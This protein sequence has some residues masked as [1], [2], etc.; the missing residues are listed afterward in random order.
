MADDG[1][2]I[3]VSWSAAG[4]WASERSWTI[5]DG[6]LGGTQI[7]SGDGTNPVNDLVGNCSPPPTNLIPTSGNSIH[8]DCSGSVYDNGGSG[9]DYSSSAN[10]SLTIYPDTPGALVNITGTSTTE[11]NFDYFYVYDGETVTPGAL[12][13]TYTGS[14][15]AVNHTSSDASGALTIRLTSDGTVTESGVDLAVTCI[16]PCEVPSSLTSS[17]ETATTATISWTVPSSAPSDGYD[18]YYDMEQLKNEPE[19]QRWWELTDPCQGPLKNRQPDEQWSQM[20]EVYY[21]H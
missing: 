1:D 20:E 2:D 12:L 6:Y 16:I 15:Q 17:L 19:N 8:T 9:G 3:D 13:A 11:A 5:D 14:G 21:N 7:G 18:Y 10:G 4:S